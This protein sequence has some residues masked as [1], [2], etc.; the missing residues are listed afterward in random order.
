MLLTNQDFLN[1]TVDA[2]ETDLKKII[3]EFNKLF[4]SAKTEQELR[5]VCV[6]I[7][8]RTSTNLILLTNQIP[9]KY[10]VELGNKI[11]AVRAAVDLAFNK[12]LSE[13]RKDNPTTLIKCKQIF[14]HIKDIGKIIFK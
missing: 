9:D 12:R 3:A 13:I 5:D 8:G 6:D 14:S 1:P 4:N 7:F 10:K 11:D 2:I